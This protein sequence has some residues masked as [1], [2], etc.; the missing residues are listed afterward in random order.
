VDIAA[1]LHSLGMQQYEAAFRDNAVDAAILPELTV[2]DLKD[3]GVTLVGHRRRLLAAIAAL[4]SDVV[5]PPEL[6]TTIAT[7]ERRQLTVMFCD[8][9]WLDRTRRAIRSRGSA[10]GHRRLPPRCHGNCGRVRWLRLQVYGRRCIGLFRLPASARGRRRAGSAS[11][12]ARHSGS[13]D[14]ENGRSRPTKIGRSTCDWIRHNRSSPSTH[15]ASKSAI[16]AGGVDFS[17]GGRPSAR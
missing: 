9:C 17:N 14:T 8:H 7:A 15:C 16:I 11:R 2:D 6:D 13:T 10:R 3:L 5:S 4:R 12:A 1:W